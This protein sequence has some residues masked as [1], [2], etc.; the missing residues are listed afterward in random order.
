VVEDGTIILVGATTENPSFELNAALLSRCHVLV[1]HRLDSIALEAL[2]AR[3]E[4]VRRRPLPLTPNSRTALIAMADGDGRYLL[5]LAEELFTLPSETPLDTAALATAVQRRMPVYDKAQ[6][7]HYNLISALHKSLRGSDVDASL[8][9]LARMLTAG[10]DPLYVVRRLVRFSVEDIGLADP[11]ALL[12]GIAAKDAYMFI[13]S[14]EG[15]LAIVQLVIYLATAPKSNSAYR[16]EKSASDAARETGSL[17]PP[18]H[19]LNA[20]TRLMKEIGYG[21][22]YQYD[23]DSETGFSGQNYFPDEMPRR[24]LYQPGPR[25]LEKEIRKRLEYWNNLREE[26]E[27]DRASSEADGGN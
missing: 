7:G 20:P 3:A 5:N 18:K 22:D 9:W 25:G 26:Q 27:T 6:D 16:A 24:A 17:M 15:E 23:H 1:L 4:E 8:Y 11:N 14:P 12:Q 19:I 21:A 10:E 2:L 13:G